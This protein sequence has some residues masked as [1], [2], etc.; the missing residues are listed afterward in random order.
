MQG[1]TVVVTD[2]G[3]GRSWFEMENDQ[4]WHA[5]GMIRHTLKVVGPGERVLCL[6]EFERYQNDTCSW[7]LCISRHGIGVIGGYHGVVK[8]I[9]EE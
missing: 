6:A 1:R 5:G 3:G 8:W 7:L 4:I 2:E 9:I